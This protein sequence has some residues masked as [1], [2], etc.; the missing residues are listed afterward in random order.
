MMHGDDGRKVLDFISENWGSLFI[1]YGFI[2][3]IIAILSYAGFI[4]IPITQLTL[5]MSISL[6]VGVTLQLLSS[7]IELI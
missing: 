5:Y 6:A 2:I 7:L 3:F 1:L 4:K